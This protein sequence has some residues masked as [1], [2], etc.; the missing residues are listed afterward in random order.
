M[1]DNL[2]PHFTVISA[3]SH[4]FSLRLAALQMRDR[5]VLAEGLIQLLPPT[6]TQRS[7]YWVWG[8]LKENILLFSSRAV[9]T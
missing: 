3:V 1:P 7:D 5:G 6:V 8:A 9:R 4:I 2:G